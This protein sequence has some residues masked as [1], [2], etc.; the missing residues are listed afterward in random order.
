[1]IIAKIFHFKQG[2]HAYISLEIHKARMKADEPVGYKYKSAQG[3]G[4]SPLNC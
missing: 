2:K 3:N 1:M 4:L